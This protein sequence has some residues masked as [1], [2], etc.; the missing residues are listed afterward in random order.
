MNLNYG[1]GRIA[2]EKKIKYGSESKRFDIV[3]YDADMNPFILVE[4]KSHDIKLN[5]NSLFQA[6][7]YN[8]ALKAPYICVS[9]GLNSFVA[10]IDFHS[11]KI[12][13]M[14]ELPECPARIIN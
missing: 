6:S 7:R 8:I 3:I 4:C 5:Q 13:K 2:V 11:M 14:E 1:S 12:E 9:N 10:R